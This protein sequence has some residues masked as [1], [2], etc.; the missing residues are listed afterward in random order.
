MKLSLE[1]LQQYVSL[2]KG[3][4]AAELQEKLTMSTVEVEQ[5][6]DLAAPLARVVVGE[7]L[8]VAPHPNADRLRLARC[9][10]GAG[11]RIDIV[12]GGKNLAVAQKVAVALPGAVV[13]GRDGAPVTI[14]A[15]EI[16][17]QPSGGMLCSAT[18]LGLVALFPR[19]GEGE[20]LDLADLATKPGQP[21]AE[22]IGFDDKVLEIDNKS[23]TNRPDLW[24]HYGIARELAAIYDVPLAPPA[25][26]R[27]PAGAAGLTVQIEDP[28]RCGRYSATR[29]TGVRDGPSPL[30]L[31]SRLARVGQRPISLLVDLTNYVMLA[32][33]Q[34]SHA[35][36]ARL[37][38]GAITVRNARA[39]EPIELL[40]GAKLE[41]DEQTL[42]IADER[43][44]VAL[45]GVMG[46]R[47]ASVFDDTTELILEVAHFAPG[48]IRRTAT[49]L[50]VR[51]ESSMRFEKGQDPNLV[52]HA[53]GVFAA[54]SCELLPSAKIAGHVDAYPLPLQPVRVRVPVAKIQRRLGTP[55]DARTMRAA[56]LR[57][58]F[59][60]D[61]QGEEL[62]LSVPSWRATGDVSIPEDIIEEVA[63]L[64]GY[65]KLAFVP[66]VVKLTAPVHQPRVT[67]ERRIKEYLAHRCGMQELLSYPW[68][69]DKHLD[70][71]GLKDEPAL[72]LATPPS[73][74]ARRLAT[75]LVP[76]LFA[77][78]AH[79]S[80][81]ADELRLFEIGRVF[82]PGERARLTC[83]EERLPR[84][85][86]RLAGAV[87]GKDLDA[88]FLAAKGILEHMSAAVQMEPLALVPAR[89]GQPWAEPAASLLVRLKE[90]E[91]GVL[92]A[93]T[94]ASRQKASVRHGELVLF[95][96]E[97]DALLP[98]PSREHRFVPFAEYPTSRCD[99]NFV[100]DETVRWQR[101]ADLAAAAHPLV[102]SVA[103]VDEYR[104]AQVPAGKKSLTMRLTL[105]S[106]KGT[107]T[108]AEIEACTRQVAALLTEKLGGALRG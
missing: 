2:P 38:D 32:V 64:H 50:G 40:D 97:V 43:G 17:G 48:G 24:G 80:R 57:L 3:L 69:Q 104:G 87:F 25:S 86:K 89:G 90:H 85:P 41:L 103:F 82:L 42:V 102:R 74:D 20:I 84:Q 19:L 101:V 77:A 52:S 29:I 63:R 12:C 92:A 33:G 34:P 75:S 61:G 53:L 73:P 14:A 76:Q 65:D 78:V 66:P 91:I 94:A 59:R 35:F 56:L 1:W 6:I 7:V 36:D 49:R 16:R 98:L 100:L 108:A 27:P 5:V 26:F 107:L 22:V 68:V 79:N 47:R 8:E 70:A 51:T 37:L 10:L 106:D 81:F 46:G 18:E 39:K 45:A 95:E 55:I 11:E 93:T 13:Q 21:F 72:N 58:G 9:E 105:G 54:L 71:A 44:P 4:D 15:G 23:L 99:L 60:D 28:K 31:Q 62:D 30:W 83:D 88:A 67:M 96:L